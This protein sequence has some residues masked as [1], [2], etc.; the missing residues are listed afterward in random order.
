[1]RSLL[2]LLIIYIVG[3][4]DESF[5]LNAHIRMIPKIMALDTRLSSKSPSFKATLAVVY[6][7]NQKNAAFSI[8]EQINKVHNGKVSNLAFSATAYSFD[9]LVERRDIAFIYIV[10]RCNSQLIK[11]V[12]VWGIVHSVPTFSYDVTDLEYGILGSIAIERST[13]VY[14][15]KNTLKEGKFRFNDILFQIARIIE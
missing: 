3:V 11:K 6:D 13:V 14:I 15:N 4:A 1:M 7:T 2:L 10:P 12:A 9:E 5:V 8:A